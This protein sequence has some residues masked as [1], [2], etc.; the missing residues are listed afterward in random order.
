MRLMVMSVRFLTEKWG[1]PINRREMKVSRYKMYKS[2]K[3][4][5]F[6]GV[7]LLAVNVQLVSVHADEAP[8]QSTTE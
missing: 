3:L 6:A 1:I 8:V 7:T 2:G 5:L 4:W